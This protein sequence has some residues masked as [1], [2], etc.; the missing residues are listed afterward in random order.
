VS[1]ASPEKNPLWGYERIRGELLKLDHRISSTSILNL[2]VRRRVL[3][4]RGGRDSS[5]T[6]F[7]PLT[8]RPSWPA[9]T[10]RVDTEFLKRIYQ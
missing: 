8:A 6:A 1:F 3:P 2:L 7:C 9:T 5:G 10:S 4:H